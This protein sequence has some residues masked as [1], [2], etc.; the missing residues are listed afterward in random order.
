MSAERLDRGIH[1]GE[2]LMPGM[3][4]SVRC[5]PELGWHYLEECRPKPVVFEPS[6]CPTCG[7]TPN[8]SSGAA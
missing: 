2:F 8:S 4:I 6:P 1:A 7:F 3:H 5:D